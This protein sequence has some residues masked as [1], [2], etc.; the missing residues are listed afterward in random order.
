MTAAEIDGFVLMIKR[1]DGKSVAHFTADG[2][3]PN[4]HRFRQH[5]DWVGNS[6]AN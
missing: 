6:P 4:G 5:V 2:Q 1:A 3:N